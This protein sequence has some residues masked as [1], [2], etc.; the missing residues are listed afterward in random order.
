MVSSARMRTTARAF[1]LVQRVM[2]SR[3]LAGHAM[4]Q[5]GAVL[6]GAVW[7]GVESRCAV[8]QTHLTFGKEFSE[9]IEKKQVAQQEAERSKFVVMKVPLRSGG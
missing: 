6:S 7:S 9:A 2:A 8:W 1:R 5:R 3:D 4:A